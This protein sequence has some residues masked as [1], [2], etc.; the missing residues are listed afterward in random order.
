MTHLELLKHLYKERKILDKI[1]KQKENAFSLG[2]ESSGLITKIGSKVELSASYRN[3]VDSTLNRI[4]YGIIF[5]TY[6]SEL[7]MLLKYKKRYVEEKKESYLGDILKLIHTIFLKLDARDKEIRLL[8]VKIENETSLELDLLIEKAMDILE[9]I[10]EIGKANREVKEHFDSELYTISNETQELIEIIYP[11]LLNFVDNIFR[12]LERIKQFIARTRKLRLQNKKLFALANDIVN[13]KDE[14]LEEL[15]ILEPKRCY[16]TLKRSQR[17]SVK[18]YPDASEAS[19]VIAKLKK[20]IFNVEVKKPPRELHIEAPKE[21]FLP[22]V[23]ISK[24][25]AMFLTQGSEDIFASIYQHE[26]LEKYVSLVE[27][28][29]LK[30]E[31]FKVYLQ[32]VIPFNKNIEITKSYNDFDV[33]VARFEVA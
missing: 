11:Q 8:L 26:E 25:E 32:F 4:D 23:N 29:S 22:L 19:R 21:E 7:E 15:L 18:S 3:F 14:A 12:S 1:Y 20:E 33:K 31:S 2:L 17:F 16:I 24:I 5:N 13:E 27:Y 6:S 28:S 9:K 30:E 10:E